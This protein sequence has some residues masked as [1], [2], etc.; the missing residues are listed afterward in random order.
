MRTGERI[1]IRD[2]DGLKW[3]ATVTDVRTD[4]ESVDITAGGLFPGGPPPDHFRQSMPG[5]STTT[6]TIELE[7]PR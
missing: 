2:A 7:G 3:W 5:R 1:K 4:V 6:V